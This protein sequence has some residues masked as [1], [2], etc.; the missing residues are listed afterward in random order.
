MHRPARW[1]R[2]LGSLALAGLALAGLPGCSAPCDTADMSGEW[3]SANQKLRLTLHPDG[4]YDYQFENVL[5]RTVQVAGSPW[6][7]MREPNA[8]VLN[9]FPHQD[10]EYFKA[11]WS[12]RP[13]TGSQKAIYLMSVERRLFSR[14]C[15]L[16][17]D[18]DTPIHLD[19][20]R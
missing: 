17:L 14:R 6:E 1:A 3:Q 12:E 15:Y 9:H 10:R 8:V 18:P 16:S 7:V 5:H 19:K 13:A 20:L 2:W 11:G 4:R